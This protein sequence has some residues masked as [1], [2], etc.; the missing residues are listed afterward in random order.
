M[1]SILDGED[2][3]M[4]RGPKRAKGTKFWNFSHDD[5]ET[6]LK[7]TSM[8]T[9]ILTTRIIVLVTLIIM[10]NLLSH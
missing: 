1:K 7:N 5:K 3:P 9:I 6:P 4:P 2:I 8:H 10:V